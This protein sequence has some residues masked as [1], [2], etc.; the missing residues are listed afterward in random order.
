MIV[1]IGARGALLVAPGEDPAVVAPPSVRPV[2]TT[3]AGDTFSGALAAELARGSELAAATR[4]AVAAA[5]LSTQG[6]G[7]RGGMPDRAAVEA[8]LS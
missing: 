4:F 1:T 5:A 7:A 6:A 3:G 8:V 2:D